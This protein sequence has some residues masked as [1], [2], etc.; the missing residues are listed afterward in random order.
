MIQLK[1]NSLEQ[2]CDFLRN[3]IAFCQKNNV[4][5]NEVHSI[6]VSGIKVLVESKWFENAIGSLYDSNTM[7]QVGFKHIV[8]NIVTYV[9]DPSKCE[10]DMVLKER[11]ERDYLH[12]IQSLK[13]ACETCEKR[14]DNEKD[15]VQLCS[16]MKILYENP[17]VKQSMKLLYASSR[18]S[19]V[20]FGQLIPR[21]A[22]GIA[23]DKS[24]QPSS[25]IPEVLANLM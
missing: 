17:Q 7:V 24:I 6:F 12:I 22:E 20:L 8:P 13:E 19:R 10:T 18:T 21:L 16:D 14:N 1:P 9:T 4:N 2:G 25:N 11:Y 23:N 3:S 5:T 15:M